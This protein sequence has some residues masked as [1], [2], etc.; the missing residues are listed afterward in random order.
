MSRIFRTALEFRHMRV[1]IL[2]LS[3]ILICAAPFPHAQIRIKVAPPLIKNEA[4]PSNAPER[5]PVWLI[6]KL[7]MKS[8]IL[9][10]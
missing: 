4:S 6:S 10:R 3:P 1:V 9:E 2:E 8:R 7:P 5:A